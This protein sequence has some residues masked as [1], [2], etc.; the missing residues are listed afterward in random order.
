M[1][2]TETVQVLET[3][4]EIPRD[5]S[6]SLL[7]KLKIAFFRIIVKVAALHMLHHNIVLCRIFEKVNQL[8]DIR[9]RTYFEN[10][11]LPTL[12]ENFCWVHFFLTDLLDGNL[13]FGMNASSKSNCAKLAFT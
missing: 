3:L 6:R 13:A 11:D 12:L 10:L 2:N 1:Y 7:T 8:N 4:H 9:V 5:F